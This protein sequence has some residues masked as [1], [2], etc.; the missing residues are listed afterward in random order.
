M[1]RVC[2]KI[3]ALN[4]IFPRWVLT[5]L[6]RAVRV[7]GVPSMLPMPPNIACIIGTTQIPSIRTARGVN[8]IYGNS[9]TTVNPASITFIFI[10]ASG[11]DQVSGTHQRH[12]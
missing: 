8:S 7:F 3:F 6:K 4:A 12:Q 11:I 5:A 10:N 9:S 2:T 1:E